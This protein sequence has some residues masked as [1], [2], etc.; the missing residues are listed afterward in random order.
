[1]LRV[2]R[3]EWLSRGLDRLRL[4]LFLYV[5]I[6]IALAGF[7]IASRALGWDF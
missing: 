5:G 2:I 4:G 7:E 6:I 3:W 1:M